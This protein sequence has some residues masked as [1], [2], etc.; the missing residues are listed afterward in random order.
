MRAELGVDIAP[1]GVS[2][3][4]ELVREAEQLV[5]MQV[6]KIAAGVSR[7]IVTALQGD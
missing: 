4:T 1:L 6:E 7:G 2:E 3:A 5:E